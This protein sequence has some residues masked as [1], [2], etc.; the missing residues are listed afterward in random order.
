MHTLGMQVGRMKLIGRQRLHLAAAEIFGRGQ[1]VHSHVE[2]SRDI[3][4]I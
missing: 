2:V 1:E 4:Q 3:E